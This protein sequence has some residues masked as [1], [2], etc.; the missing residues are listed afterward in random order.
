[1]QCECQNT[2]FTKSFF[3]HIFLDSEAPAPKLKEGFEMMYNWKICI[4][5]K[6][7]EHDE[8]FLI[9]DLQGHSYSDPHPPTSILIRIPPPGAHVCEERSTSANCGNLW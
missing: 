8:C 3:L 2:L 7:S 6:A 4:I 9:I 5:S 1:M